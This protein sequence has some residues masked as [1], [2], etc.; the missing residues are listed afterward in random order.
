MYSYYLDLGNGLY[1]RVL[2]Q[3][4]SVSD[5]QAERVFKASAKDYSAYRVTLSERAFDLQ[6][7]DWVNM[8]PSVKVVVVKDGRPLGVL[9]H[10]TWYTCFGG[11]TIEY[12]D[13]ETRLVRVEFLEDDLFLKLVN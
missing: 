1:R 7:L 11:I 3:K 2:S 9:R 10:V 4:Y 12:E 8:E 6:G 5:I 13:K